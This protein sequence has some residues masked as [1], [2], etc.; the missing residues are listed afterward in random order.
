MNFK[1]SFGIQSNRMMKCGEKLLKLLFLERR[2]E[3]ESMKLKIM[4]FGSRF[5]EKS[6]SE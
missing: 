3:E 5:A 1:I 4:E 2:L 6:S